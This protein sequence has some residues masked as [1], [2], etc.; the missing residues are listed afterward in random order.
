MKKLFYKSGILLVQAFFL[1]SFT[2][3]AEDVSKEIHKEFKAE[4]GTNIDISNKYGK[5]IIESW[6]NNQVVIDVKITVESNNRSLAEKLLSY[7][8]VQFTEG[9]NSIGAKTVLDED[10]TFSEWGGPIRFFSRE[11]SLKTFSID[12]TVKMPAEA[13]LNLDNKYGNIEI[14]ELNGLVNIVEKYGDINIFKL[15]RGNEKPLNTVNISYGKASIEESNWLDITSRYCPRFMIQNSKALLIDTKYSKFE[16]TDVSSIV[17]NAKYDNIK[18]ENINNIVAT[19]GY[20]DF[21]IGKLTKK[22]DVQTDYGK[23]SVDEIPAGFESIDVEADYCGVELGIDRSASYSLDA[24]ARYGDIKFDEENFNIKQ[25]IYEN[26]SRKVT[27]ISGN[28]PNPESN[29][30]VRISYGTINLY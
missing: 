20:T 28:N 3:S 24:S 14:S 18:I 15:T 27:G 25:R 8:D 11:S 5:V 12:Y 22:L 17:L 7:I 2:V 9:E 23:L 26:T 13:N 10:L 6:A 1:L 19:G 21:S 16:I 4:K 29:V 30:T